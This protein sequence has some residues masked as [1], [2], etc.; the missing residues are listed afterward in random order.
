MKYAIFIWTLSL[1][2]LTQADTFEDLL[3]QIKQDSRQELAENRERVQRFKAEKANQEALLREAKARLTALVSESERLNTEV[4]N[5][6]IALAAKEEELQRKV[7]DLGELF[8][9]I[10][11]VAGELKA[12]F[13]H[14][15]ISVQH[16]DRIEDLATLAQSTQLPDSRELE[17][18]WYLMLQEMGETGKTRQFNAE[19]VQ[20]D[21]SVRTQDIIRIGAYTIIS[22]GDYLQYG[23]ETNT[24][25][26]LQRRPPTRL[27]R[28][29]ESF[30]GSATDLDKIMVDPTRGQLLSMLPLKPNLWERIQQGGIIG[31]IILA[32]GATGLLIALMR[33]LYLSFVASRIN[34]QAKDLSEL[35]DKNPLGRV[36]L[37]YRK[38]RGHPVQEREIAL[39]EAILK[40][41]PVIERHNGFIKLL[42]AVAPLLGLLGTVIGMIITFQSITLFGTSDPKLMAGGISTALVTTVLG[43]S[44]AIPLLFAH[45]FIASKSKRIID[46]IEQQSVGLIAR[47]A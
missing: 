23:N 1:S 30:T 11:Q 10:R 12:D 15:A 35:S 3:H 9:A 21:G 47:Q 17:K 18:L 25:A 36:A 33:Y 4:D 16:P 24:L 39:E 34:A 37:V 20:Q 31:Y 45:T 27:Q 8:G 26:E 43:L 7:G 22:E 44:V 38:Y 46:T 19:V 28:F 29:A 5:N 41:V 42:A 2:P 40:E 13:E 6:E 32:L 14:S